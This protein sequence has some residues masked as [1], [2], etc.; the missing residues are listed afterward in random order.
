MK[1][2][3]LL[4]ALL[5]SL[6]TAAHARRDWFDN[7]PFKDL[8]EHGFGGMRQPF[9]AGQMQPQMN[10][11]SHDVRNDDGEVTR[12]YELEVPGRGKKELDLHVDENNHLITVTFK[13]RDQKKEHTSDDGLESYSYSSSSQSFQ[14]AFTP[15]ADADL[16]SVKASV[17]KGILKIKVK[18]GGVKD[19]RR[20]IDIKSDNDDDGEL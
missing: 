17:S 18:R 7:D 2:Q 13:A 9:F 4:I 20:I 1:K 10:M 11:R 8:F 15:P 6:A 19:A 5:G 3:V 16:D 14:Q 12:I